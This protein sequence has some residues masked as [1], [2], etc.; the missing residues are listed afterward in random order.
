MSDR[1]L[2][3]LVARALYG[4]GALWDH[5]MRVAQDKYRSEAKALLDAYDPA[6]AA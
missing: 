2:V 4:G 3:E 6:R 1:E 5:L